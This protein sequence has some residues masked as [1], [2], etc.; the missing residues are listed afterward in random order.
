MKFAS[1]ISHENTNKP[2]DGAYFADFGIDIN[3]QYLFGNV[4]RLNNEISSKKKK[5]YYNILELVHC[6]Y[7]QLQYNRYYDLCATAIQ[8]EY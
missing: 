7:L 2:L 4:T 8:K 6:K 5:K 1:Q 3:Q